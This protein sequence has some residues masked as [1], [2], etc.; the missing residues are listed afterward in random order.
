MKERYDRAIAGNRKSTPIQ[1]VGNGARCPAVL[2]LEDI[3]AAHL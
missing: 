2:S 3:S 1:T